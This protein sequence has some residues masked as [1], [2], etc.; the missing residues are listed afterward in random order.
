M[1][2][3]DM[4]RDDMREEYDFTN[5]VRT[6]KYA[7]RYA[8]GTNVVLLESDVAEVFPDSQSVNAALRA[9]LKTTKRSP[10]KD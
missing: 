10:Q 1:N 3:A 8:Q 9:V 5:A 4:D 6:D 2:D 7:V